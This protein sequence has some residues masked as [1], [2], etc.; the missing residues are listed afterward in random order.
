MVVAVTLEIGQSA[1]PVPAPSTLFQAKAT[2][3]L[4]A[5][6]PV[7]LAVVV[8]LLSPEAQ[9]TVPARAV[10]KDGAF[11]SAAGAMLSATPFS[12]RSPYTHG[13]FPDGIRGPSRLSWAV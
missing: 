3:D 13:E 5:R 12:A 4:P 10:P 2:Q 6:G 9:E 11:A 1:R 8:T 7:R